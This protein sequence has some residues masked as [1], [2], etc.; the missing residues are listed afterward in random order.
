MELR[1]WCVEDANREAEQ[2]HTSPSFRLH[3]DGNMTVQLGYAQNLKYL[4]CSGNS[5]LRPLLTEIKARL[6]ICI[7]PT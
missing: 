1:D 3:V 6:H 2:V 4:T 5:M 7:V